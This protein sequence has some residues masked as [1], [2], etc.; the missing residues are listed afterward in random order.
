MKKTTAYLTVATFVISFGFMFGVGVFLILNDESNDESQGE[1]Q[2]L[3]PIAAEAAA[4]Y[5]EAADAYLAVAARYDDS[6]SLF[7][8]LE[9]LDALLAARDAARDAGDSY[10]GPD[11]ASVWL[12][13]ASVWSA[14][15]VDYADIADLFHNG[16]ETLA[17]LRATADAAEAAAGIA[18]A[19]CDAE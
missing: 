7:N 10:C 18:A 12:A 1:S 2:E 17:T 6:A 9:T 5:G 4:A 13:A 16:A 11:T 19:Y 8:D 15:A 14:A 3:V